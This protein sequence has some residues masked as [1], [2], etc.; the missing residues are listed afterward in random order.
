[1]DTHPHVICGTE[2]EDRHELP[3]WEQIIMIISTGYAIRCP[4][5][6]IR[7]LK[8]LENGCEG[9]SLALPFGFPYMIRQLEIERKIQRH[10]D[11][12]VEAVSRNQPAMPFNRTLHAILEGIISSK[13]NQEQENEKRSELR[14]RLDL[15][16]L[17][18]ED[19]IRRRFGVGLLKFLKSAL[20][21]SKDKD[22]ALFLLQR[23]S[24]SVNDEQSYANGIGKVGWGATSKEDIWQ[25]ILVFPTEMENDELGERYARQALTG[26][27]QLYQ[28]ISEHQ[29]AEATE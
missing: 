27:L 2:L 4:G 21:N 7:A 18:E 5:G 28:N 13:G 20:C 8:E 1:M 22:A 26:L 15:Y 24:E 17:P 19:I 23:N 25:E 10:E 14:A 11:A 9:D 3:T 12:L 29:N 6:L 16:T